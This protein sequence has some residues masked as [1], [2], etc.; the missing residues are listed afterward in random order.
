M[1]RL[2]YLILVISLLFYCAPKQDKVER[3][4]E[5]GVE[6]VLNHLEPYKIKGEPSTLILEEEFILDLERDDLA[7]AGMMDIGG[8][9]VDSEGNIYLWCI[10]SSEDFIFKFNPKGE[11]VR[12]IGRKGQGPGELE[13]PFNLR[14]NDRDEI[15]VSER[16]RKKLVVINKNGDFIRE[17]PIAGNHFMMTL[18]ENRKILAMQSIFIREEGVTELPIVIYNENLEEVATLHKGQKAPNWVL[19]KEINGL[20]TNVNLSSWSISKGL[21]Y[22]GNQDNGYEFLVFNSEGILIRK[23]RKEYAP[24]KVPAYVK[25][26]VF[27]RIDNHPVLKRPDLKIKNKIY[28]PD[29]MLPFQYFFTDDKGRLFVMTHE[30]GKR[31]KEFVHDIFSHDGVFIGRTSLDNSGNRLAAMWGGPFDVRAQDNRLYC[32]RGKDS[33]YQ[34]IVVHKMIWR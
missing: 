12:S 30:K 21:V 32:M 6:V 2:I 22:L 3:I 9:D 16:R 15:L 5:D 34:E 1:N 27:E 4:I 26:K 31:P 19:A 14:I 8:F 13:G 29:N 20:T 17:I 23:I 25:E 33:G 10:M 18:L 7:E 11:F 24:V 28:F